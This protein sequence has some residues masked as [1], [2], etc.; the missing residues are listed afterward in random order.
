MEY[1]QMAKELFYAC[2]NTQRLET[3]RKIN[4]I[5]QGEAFALNFLY[6][7]NNIAYPRELS[8]AM[9][10]S[11]A[12]IA[13]LLNKLESDKKITRTPDPKDCRQILVTITQEGINSIIEH[14][15]NGINFFAGLLEKLGEEDAKEYVRINKRL[16]E[17]LV[18]SI[19]DQ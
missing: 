15:K 7:H 1:E 13:R 8:N 2:F 10:V 18:Q 17:I 4:K 5:L 3:D 12:R 19:N 16:A 11:T 9:N 14:N 6:S